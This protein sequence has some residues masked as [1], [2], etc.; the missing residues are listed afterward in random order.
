M[1]NN[2]LVTIEQHRSIFEKA[3]AHARLFLSKLENKHKDIRISELKRSV[4]HLQEKYNNV[5]P[6]YQD[7]QN[8]IEV[9]QGIGVTRRADGAWIFNFKVLLER[10]EKE[11]INDLKKEL[12]IY[13]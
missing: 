2:L 13:N 7:R 10:F 3:N 11:D 6:L 5:L 12:N 4:Y 8:E 9:L 1:R